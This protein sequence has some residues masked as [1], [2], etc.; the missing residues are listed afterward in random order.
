MLF[1]SLM[2]ELLSILIPMLS[3][4]DSLSTVVFIRIIHEVD[5]L[6]FL[7]VISQTRRQQRNIIM[8]LLPMLLASP[9]LE[10]KISNDSAR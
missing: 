3:E 2:G 5:H 1:S 9:N 6:Q 7:V 10:R 4:T 8:H